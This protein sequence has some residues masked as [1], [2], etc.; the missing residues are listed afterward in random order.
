MNID[1]LKSLVI[2]EATALKST[3]DQYELE[4]LDFR[5]LDP[6]EHTSCIYGQMTGS[7]FNKRAEELIATCA[8]KLV[9]GEIGSEVSD[10][11]DCVSIENDKDCRRSRDTGDVYFSPI[12][13]FIAQNQTS[14]DC[15][16]EN[17]KI[18]IDYLKG[19]TDTLNF[20]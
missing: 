14:L 20:I 12:E 15:F 18:L 6:T 13:M 4:R 3:A 10:I 2:S 9:V 16:I 8:T 19:K 1:T 5:V 7:C 17:N 11:D